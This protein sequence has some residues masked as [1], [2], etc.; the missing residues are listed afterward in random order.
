M[1][2]RIFLICVMF[3][4]CTI[5]TRKTRLVDPLIIVD[6][7]GLVNF[8][9]EQ[10]AENRSR[11][12]LH[13]RVYNNIYNI[14]KKLDSIAREEKSFKSISMYEGGKDGEVRL[15]PDYD[16]EKD[17]CNVERLFIALPDSLFREEIVFR[18]YEYSKTIPTWIPYSQS[19][20]LMGRL[21]LERAGLL[22]AT[23]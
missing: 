17:T 14:A 23:E 9:I 16:Y 13:D 2:R 8:G 19:K 15:I 10:D 11:K 20:L 4:Q 5:F 18:L 6:T 22:P 21:L 3:T 12:E 7:V 1:N